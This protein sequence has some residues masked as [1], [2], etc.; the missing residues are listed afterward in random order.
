MIPEDHFGSLKRHLSFSVCGWIC[1]PFVCVLIYERK[2]KGTDHDLGFWEVKGH[3]IKALA[4]KKLQLSLTLTATRI[5]AAWR[6]GSPGNESTRLL[7]VV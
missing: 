5:H 2:P 4:W 3:V 1:V 6:S 7:P